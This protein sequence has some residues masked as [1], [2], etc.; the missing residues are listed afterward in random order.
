M[1]FVGGYIV[2]LVSPRPAY[3]AVALAPPEYPGVGMVS[4]TEAAGLNKPLHLYP[5][6]GFSSTKTSFFGEG[7]KVVVG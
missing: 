7:K 4:A 2:P 3:V 6:L 1:S 5:A